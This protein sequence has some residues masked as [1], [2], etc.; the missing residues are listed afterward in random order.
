[1]EFA[2]AVTV[3]RR[4]AAKNT[5]APVPAKATGPGQMMNVWKEMEDWEAVGA[6]PPLQPLLREGIARYGELV[7][8]CYK[9]LDL[10]PSSDRY[11]NC[12]YGKK[13]MLRGVGMADSGYYVTKYIYAAPHFRLPIAARSCSPWIGYVAVSSSDC[14]CRC[15]EILVSFRGTVT[16][17]EWIANLMSSLEAARFDPHDPR[18]DVKVASGF[19]S[20]YTSGDS[21]TKFGSGSCREQLLS[22][23]SRLLC[24]YKGEEVS[25]TL[26]GH[27]MGSALALL[28]GYDIA[29]PG[30]NQ[31]GRRRS[32]PVMVCSF[33]GPRVGNA[34]FKRRCEELGVKVL[35]VVNVNDLVT[36]LPGVIFNE[37]FR[38]PVGGGRSSYAHVGVELALDFFEVQDYPACVHDL[39]AYIRL[40]KCPDS[41]DMVR[42][43]RKGAAS[44]AAF[45]IVKK[46]RECSGRSQ[47]LDAWRWQD[48]AMHVSHWTSEA[49][50][51]LKGS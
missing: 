50:R 47:R 13:S 43:K 22:E 28:L 36:K 44:A 34:E 14:L 5:P 8:A 46:A 32:A 37:K 10:D 27:S 21:S 23:L 11:L 9:A 38:N 1:M 39:D 30:L 24:E 41:D 3:P 12:K 35:R 33:G 25:I 31:L 19:L 18:L 48:A 15:R 16:S 51:L 45:D 49:G 4:I 42:A 40:L 20:L 29:E 7:A 6:A 17:T 2:T 26:A